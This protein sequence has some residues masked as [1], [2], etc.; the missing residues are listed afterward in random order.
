MEGLGSTPA[1]LLLV[2]IV[3]RLIKGVKTLI[4]LKLGNREEKIS[5]RR[6]AYCGGR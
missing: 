5:L 4:E 1:K 2:L 3:F 6:R